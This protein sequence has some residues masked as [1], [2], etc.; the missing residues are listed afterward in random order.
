MVS[1]DTAGWIAP[2]AARRGNRVAWHGGRRLWKECR[3]TDDVVPLDV[4]G[5]PSGTSPYDVAKFAAMPAG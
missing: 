3:K 1:G 5:A 2:C 4:G